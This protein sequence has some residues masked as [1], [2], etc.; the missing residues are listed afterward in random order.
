MG[1]CFLLGGSADGIC[2]LHGGVLVMGGKEANTNARN[3][4]E[5]HLFIFFFGGAAVLQKVLSLTRHGVRGT[6]ASC[7][8]R[9]FASGAHSLDKASDQ[10]FDRPGICAKA[11]TFTYVSASISA[12]SAIILFRFSALLAFLATAFSAARLSAL[13]SNFVPGDK[14][15]GQL[16]KATKMA[17]AS[18]KVVHAGSPVFA[19][20]FARSS[21]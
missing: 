20:N 14:S 15:F 11:D 2:S 17:S 9:T 6:A 21:V 10:S 5:H 18:H 16:F 3:T 1:A 4:C 12:I 13:I 8:G 7:T 19:I